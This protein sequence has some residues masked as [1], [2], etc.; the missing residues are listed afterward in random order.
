MNPKTAALIGSRIKSCRQSARETLD[1]VAQI[2]D[3][4]KTTVMRWE[5]GQTEKIALGHLEKLAAHFQID[6]DWLAARPPYDRP[7]QQP[8]PAPNDE[9]WQIR[10]RLHKQPAQKILFDATA[11]MTEEDLQTV[12]RMVRAW[13]G[14]N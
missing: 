2:V 7:Q 13:K 3:V 1:D 9:V 12:I 4:N 8:P 6:P 10:E 5:K 14:G 11:D